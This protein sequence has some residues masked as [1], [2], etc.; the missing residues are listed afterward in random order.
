MK[1]LKKNATTKAAGSL[2][3]NEEQIPDIPVEQNHPQVSEAY[4]LSLLE[5]GV[6]VGEDTAI[7]KIPLD[8]LT[9]DL[10]NYQRPP[11]NKISAMARNWDNFQA[12]T[13]RVN[14]KD[15]R[16]NVVDGQCRVAAARMIGIDRLPAML[17]LNQTKDWE[18]DK[19][20]TQNENVTRITPYD[21]FYARWHKSYDLDPVAHEL[22]KLLDYYHIVYEAPHAGM[23]HNGKVVGRRPSG[24]QGGSL[25]CLGDVMKLADSGNMELLASVFKIIR[26]QNWHMLPRTY[27][28]RFFM[29]LVHV[30][31]NYGE[32]EVQRMLQY[33]LNGHSPNAIIGLARG[34]FSDCSEGEALNA[35]FDKLMKAN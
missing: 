2:A 12:N 9:I 8:V 30:C 32:Q 29:A 35:L 23:V 4:V 17:T 11:T 1:K 3:L 21:L 15:G 20:V 26:L 13:I 16:L 22:K 6:S 10:D 14:Y 34:Q 33:R 24:R 25:Q 27:S 31:R 7:C 5:G 19:F 28:S 18:I